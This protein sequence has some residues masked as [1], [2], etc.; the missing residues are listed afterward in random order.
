MLGTYTEAKLGQY[1]YPVFL[2][3]EVNGTINS[4]NSHTVVYCSIL[5]YTGSS[6]VFINSLSLQKGMD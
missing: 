5:L 4:R 6:D 3:W 2:K 1:I